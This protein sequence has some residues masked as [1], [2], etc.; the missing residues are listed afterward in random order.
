[1]VYNVFLSYIKHETAEAYAE[2]IQPE[3]TDWIKH[4]ILDQFK[5]NIYFVF[6]RNRL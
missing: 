3:H 5:C 1:M 2:D 6:C 4:P